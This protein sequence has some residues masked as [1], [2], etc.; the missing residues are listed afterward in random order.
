LPL[1]T[2]SLEV[3]CTRERKRRLADAVYEALRA[4]I[5]IPENDRFV[6]IREHAAG[7]LVADPGYLGVARS[8]HPM[9]VEITL[10]RGQPTE[11]KQALY[12]VFA[13]SMSGQQPREAAFLDGKA[14]SGS[15]QAATSLVKTVNREI[16]ERMSATGLVRKED[17]LIVLHENDSADWSFGAG[18]AQYV[19]AAQKEA[20]QKQG[21][22]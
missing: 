8:E 12:T 11:K 20:G 3:G 19:E 2:L 7:D 13:N 6:A 5:Q 21:Q 9:F 4:G 17:L 1:V 22:P 15:V 18:V 10:R 16:A 14:A